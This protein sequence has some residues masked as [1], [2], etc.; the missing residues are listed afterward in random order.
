MFNKDIRNEFK[1]ADVRQWEVA[2]A[3][4]ICEVT[5][6]KMLR[7]ELPE[8]KKLVIRAAISKAKAFKT[9]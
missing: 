6:T 7:R 1:A 2:E 5:L 3:M 9:K 4:G 8:E